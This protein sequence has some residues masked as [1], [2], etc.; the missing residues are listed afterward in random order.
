MSLFYLNHHLYSMSVIVTL[1][2]YHAS[3]VGAFQIITSLS[4]SS[5]LMMHNNNDP[6]Y[7]GDPYNNNGMPPPESPPPLYKI[8]RES[9]RGFTYGPD[10]GTSAK[11]YSL[12]SSPQE[13]SS[14][15]D[16]SDFGQIIAPGD[17]YY[18]YQFDPNDDPYTQS[19][20]GLNPNAGVVRPIIR[21]N[22]N[23]YYSGSGTLMSEEGQRHQQRGRGSTYG[24]EQQQYQP[25]PIHHEQQQRQGAAAPPG[26]MDHRQQ[27]RAA[28]PAA[29]QQPGMMDRRPE[30][31]SSKTDDEVRGTSTFD[32][33]GTSS[34]TVDA[35][36]NKY[37]ENVH[38][39]PP[40]KMDTTPP[41]NTGFGNRYTA[42][43]NVGAA[44]TLQQQQYTAGHT[45]QQKQVQYNDHDN[46]NNNNPYYQKQQQQPSHQQQQQQQQ[47]SHQ[48]QQQQQPSYQQQQQQQQ[49][50]FNSRSNTRSASS[51]SHR[52][53]ELLEVVE[54]GNRSKVPDVIKRALDAR[55]EIGYLLK[56]GKKTLENK[57]R[58]LEYDIVRMELS[59]QKFEACTELENLQ[60]QLQS[61]Y[62]DFEEQLD[63]QIGSILSPSSALF[64]KNLNNERPIFPFVPAERRR[65]NTYDSVI[66]PSSNNSTAYTR[67]SSAPPFQF[68]PAS[69][70][71]SAD[72]EL[73][74]G[75]ATTTTTANNDDD[76]ILIYDP[77]ETPPPIIDVEYKNDDRTRENQD[78]DSPDYQEFT[79]TT[80]NEQQR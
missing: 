37:Q 65:S 75:Y 17:Q 25:Q 22:T 69:S 15:Y 11:R 56:E 16:S 38:I 49:Q 20:D 7:N 33:G 39:A 9:S 64:P 78:Y 48:Q 27:E 5:C 52:I 62:Y 76:E 23:D 63:R 71:A 41:A 80:H 34:V 59:S 74:Y 57:I 68:G 18:N 32:Y 36:S 60:H 14:Y 12:S 10:S 35:D 1:L 46:N 3:L 54:Q 40:P 55:D 53:Q 26:M 28:A 73:D 45:Q 6:Y 79:T 70:I 29:A 47:P 19:N 24:Q 8:E 58:T 42:N 2:Y 4:S 67:S 43:A 51:T 61:E 72:A 30:C 13:G 77:D 21:A 66:Q 44:S 31:F 50:Y